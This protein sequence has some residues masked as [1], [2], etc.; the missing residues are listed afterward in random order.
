ME[1][2]SAVASGVAHEVNN[3]LQ[4]MGSNLDLLS[5]YVAGDPDAEEVLR[6]LRVGLAR[7]SKLSSEL[8][9]FSRQQ[10][11][12]PQ[13]GNIRDI[14]GISDIPRRAVAE[15]LQDHPLPNAHGKGGVPRDASRSG[16]K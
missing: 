16:R 12:S 7:G 3:I 2:V 4:I 11:P 6:A 9:A 5:R 10:A 13:G 14:F 15:P 8:Q 1:A